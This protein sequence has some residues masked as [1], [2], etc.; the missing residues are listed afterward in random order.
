M[1]NKILNYF[2]EI[3]NIPRCSYH[4]EKIGKYLLDWGKQHNFITKQD[5]IGNVIIYV[6]ASKGKE[7]SDSV[8][9]QGHMD[10][11]CEKNSNSTH[12]F[13]KDAISLIDE[14]EWITA[15]DTTL[16]A[17]NGIA[18]AIAMAISLDEEVEH[19]PLELLFTVDEEVGLD[20]AKDITPN[21]F[22]SKM[23]INI[24]SE[25]EGIVTI[26]CAGGNDTNI[27]YDFKSVDNEFSNIYKLMISGL[28]GGHSG[29]DIDN[30]R[31]NPIKLLAETISNIVADYQLSEFV[32]GTAHNAIP[33]EGYLIFSTNKNLT[34]DDFANIR[35]KFQNKL[36]IEVDLKLGLTKAQNFISQDDSKSIIDLIDQLP[37]GVYN[38]SKKIGGLVQTSNNLAIFRL[39]NGKMK[40]KSSQRGAT[41]DGLAELTNKIETIG[42]SFGYYTNSPQGYPSWEPNFHSKLLAKSKNV[43]K[44]IFGK[45]LQVEIIHAGLECGIIG[46]LI[47]D[48]D[49]ISIGPTIQ[50]PHTPKERI[51]KETI[52]YIYTLI[53][54]LLA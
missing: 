44:N 5:D 49:M 32:S 46:S 1:I 4:N 40:A 3:C 47:P 6:P 10:M 17:D 52:G 2:E 36:E 8:I 21:W 28:T 48:L 38:Y 24:D 34:V 39:E 29:M 19:P 14:G 30:N 23:L 15:K 22:K 33:R 26:G 43:Y 53:K 9:L 42:K 50:N 11:V 37:H 41:V 18:L 51:K 16:G 45:D 25:D 35:N 54:G 12:D 27:S 13:S 31:G 7:N 20:G